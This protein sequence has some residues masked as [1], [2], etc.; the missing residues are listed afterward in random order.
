MCVEMSRPIRCIYQSEGII[1]R[2]R[3]NLGVMN[4]VDLDFGR[5]LT[6]AERAAPVRHLLILEA[7]SG[8]LVVQDLQRLA[9]CASWCQENQ[10]QSAV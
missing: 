6:Q 9:P 8:Q 4:P 2:L 10:Q 5:T 1:Y 3:S 7:A